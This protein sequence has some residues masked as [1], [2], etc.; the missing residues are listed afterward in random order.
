[1]C[2]FVAERQQ[3][4]GGIFEQIE[5]VFKVLGTAIIGVGHMVVG[6]LG[7]EIGHEEYLL[8]LGLRTRQSSQ[9][10]QIGSIH[11]DDPIEAGKVRRHHRPRTMREAIAPTSRMA[12]HSRIGQFALVVINETG[13]VELELIGPADFGHSMAKHLLGCHRTTDVAK[14]NEQYLF[15]FHIPNL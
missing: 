1:M 5:Y 12:A 8:L 10:A 2:L 7:E 6:M 13:R 9:A 15:C 11:T 3:A 4:S 14:T